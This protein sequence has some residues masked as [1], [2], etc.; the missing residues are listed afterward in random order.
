MIF[1]CNIDLDGGTDS[2]DS[3]GDDN[4]VT[5]NQSLIESASNPII[6]KLQEAVKFEIQFNFWK[7]RDELITT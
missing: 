6:R 2:D 5:I 7:D 1:F 3:E 4:E